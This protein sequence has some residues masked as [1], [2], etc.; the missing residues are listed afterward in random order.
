MIKIRWDQ[1]F[2]RTYRK[3][4]KNDPDLR[5][6]FWGGNGVVFEKSLPSEIE[7]S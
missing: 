1:G 5:E 4:V 6:R 3:K 7:N 2:K